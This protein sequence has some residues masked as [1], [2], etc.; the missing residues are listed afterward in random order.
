VTTAPRP[1]ICCTMSDSISIKGDSFS[2]L[3]LSKITGLYEDGITIGRNQIKS[4]KTV[5]DLWAAFRVFDTNGDGHISFEEL[6]DVVRKIRM[7]HS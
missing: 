3:D 5:N 7:T 2:G 6:K 4:K 1:I